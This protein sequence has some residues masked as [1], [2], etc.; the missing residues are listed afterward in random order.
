MLSCYTGCCKILGDGC[1]IYF[2]K[3]VPINVDRNMFR[4]RDTKYL[5]LNFLFI[6]IDLNV[7]FFM[8]SEYFYVHQWRSCE[9]I[10]QLFLIKKKIC[11]TDFFLSNFSIQ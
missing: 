10:P 7:H 11:A 6:F 1:R 2:V 8:V 9:N 3:K 4:F 5:N